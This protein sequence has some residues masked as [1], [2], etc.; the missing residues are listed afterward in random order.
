MNS[1]KN[2]HAILMVLFI[3]FALISCSDDDDRNATPLD[4][5]DSMVSALGVVNL[6]ISSDLEGP[7]TG[8]ADFDHMDLGS[9]QV[10]EISM[11]D[12]SPKTFD[13]KIR[14][15]SEEAS[16]PE[17]GSYGIGSNVSDPNIYWVDFTLFENHDFAK[18]EE[19]STMF[20]QAGTLIIET[21]NDEG[22]SGSIEF[23]GHKYLDDTTDMISS[24]TVSGNF[25]ARPKVFY[26]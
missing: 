24:I 2:T 6:S 12:Y 9:R 22:V 10:W 23:T 3:S 25:T 11:Q 26:Y 19:Y 16:R 15:I 21:S 18:A 20:E 7:R 17:P 5:G 4:I 14:Q 8:I 13:L 1:F